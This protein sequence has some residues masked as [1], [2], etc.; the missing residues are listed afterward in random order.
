TAEQVLE[1]LDGLLLAGGGDVDP[2]RYGG[3]ATDHLYGVDPAR[4]EL[5]I[6]LLRAADAAATPTL[7]I[8]RG[9][10]VMNVAFGGTLHPHLPDVPGLLQHG[11]P[12][13]DT[14]TLHD[15]GVEPASRLFATT[16]VSTLAAS[17]HHHQGVDR[18]G[19]GLLV[20]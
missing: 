1:P 10:Q 4:D 3:S 11:V 13:L 14:Q 16:K 8:C 9:M 15:V 19:G 5:E 20:S 12:V 2:A 18:A 17:S 6:E 7:C